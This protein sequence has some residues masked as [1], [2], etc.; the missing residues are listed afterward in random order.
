MGRRPLAGRAAGPLARCPGRAAS[1]GDVSTRVPGLAVPRGG[2]VRHAEPDGT[3]GAAASGVWPAAGRSHVA[4]DLDGGGV[5]A[6]DRNS[7][8]NRLNAL[9]ALPL[10][11]RRAWVYPW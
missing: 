7:E 6:E 8:R 3:D 11:R 5:A 1:D 4:R 2:A 9:V 10:R